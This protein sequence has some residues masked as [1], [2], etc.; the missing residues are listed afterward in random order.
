MVLVQSGLNNEQVLL[1]RS[2]Y[3]EKCI[4]ALKHVVS[5]AKI[6]LISS[7]LFAKKGN[8]KGLRNSM[9]QI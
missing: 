4:L 9:N 6:V 1:M 7:G 8:N 5:I 2:M 3:I